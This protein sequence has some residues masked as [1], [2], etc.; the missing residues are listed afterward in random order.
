VATKNFKPSQ[1]YKSS[2][3]RSRIILLEL[4]AVRLY[5]MF[6]IKSIKNKKLE[7]VQMCV[8]SKFLR[9]YDG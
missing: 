8:S 2:V 7:T 5:S 6:T 3:P 9:G 4:S 1:L